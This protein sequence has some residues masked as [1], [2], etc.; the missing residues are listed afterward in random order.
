MLLMQEPM[1]KTH[2]KEPQERAPKPRQ[3]KRQRQQEAMQPLPQ[4]VPER[5]RVP[6]Y[7]RMG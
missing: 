4:E 1:S 3:L 5:D 2:R 7:G 6:V